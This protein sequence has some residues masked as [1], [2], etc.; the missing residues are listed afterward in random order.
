MYTI[1]EYAY[2]R[3]I[4]LGTVLNATIIELFAGAVY[5]AYKKAH[6]QDYENY[7]D[8]KATKKSELELVEKAKSN[9]KKKHEPEVINPRVLL[10]IEKESGPDAAREIIRMCGG[11]LNGLTAVLSTTTIFNIS[12]LPEDKYDYI[13]NLKRIMI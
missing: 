9:G 13:I 2:S 1:R 11:K 6:I 5:I 12:S 7:A 8:Y 4:V 3:T 10:A